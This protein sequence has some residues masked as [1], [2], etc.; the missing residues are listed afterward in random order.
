MIL[1]ILIKF[2]SSIIPKRKNSQQYSRSFHISCS[3]LFLYILSLVLNV[4]FEKEFQVKQCEH[5][6][7]TEQTV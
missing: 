4:D 3:F 5:E 1:Y 7:Q 6:S 2:S